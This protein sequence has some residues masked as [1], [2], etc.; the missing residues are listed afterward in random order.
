MKKETFLSEISEILLLENPC[1]EDEI[2]ND[3]EEWDSLAKMSVMTF[4]NNNWGISFT[5]NDMNNLVTVKD[6]I[7]MAG[8]NIDE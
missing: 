1:N 4:F 2:L 3:F 6:L 5:M 7:N 8:D